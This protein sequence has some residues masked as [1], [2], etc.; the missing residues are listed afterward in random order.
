[1]NEYWTLEDYAGGLAIYSGELLIMV[2]CHDERTHAETM[3]DWRNSVL[4]R[5]YP[6]A[7]AA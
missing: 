4:D 2:L 3:I 7:V 1:M 5:A 6:L